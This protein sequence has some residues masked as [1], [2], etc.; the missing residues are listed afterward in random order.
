MWIGT[1]ADQNMIGDRQIVGADEHA[2]SIRGQ[3]STFLTTLCDGRYVRP[4][5]YRGG[6][7]VASGL[8]FPVRVC[9]PPEDGPAP[10]W[11]RAASLDAVIGV[12]A[13]TAQVTYLCIIG[14]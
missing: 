6:S 2:Q 13:C 8:S 4:L 14:P 12:P 9:V 5:T 1:A 3:I 11:H 7:C 10:G